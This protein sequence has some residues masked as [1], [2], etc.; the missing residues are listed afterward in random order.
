MLFRH[1]GHDD[2]INMKNLKKIITAILLIFI[3]S[4][5]FVSCTDENVTEN[6]TIDDNGTSG[7]NNESSADTDISLPNDNAVWGKGIELRIVI[8]QNSNFEIGKIINPISEITDTPAIPVTDVIEEAPHEFVLGKANRE[9]S[10]LAYSALDELLSG[11]YDAGWLLYTKGNSLA[12]AYSSDIA[13]ELSL[14]YLFDELFLRSELVFESEGVVVSHK[15]DIRS[16]AD[17]MREDARS[18]AFDNFEKILGKESTD[19][20]KKLYELYTSDLCSWFAGLYDKDIGGFYFSNSGRDNAGFLPDIESTVQALNHLATGGMFVNYSNSYAYALPKEMKAALLAFAKGLQ[21]SED[22]YFYHPQWGTSIIVSRRGRD[23]GW[24]TQLIKSLGGRPYWNTPGG[25][26]GEYGAPGLASTAALTKK[27]SEKAASAVSCITQTSSYLPEYLRSLDAW[28]D[29]IDGLGIYDDPYTSGNTLAAQH[30]EIKNAGKEYID[31]LINYLNELQDEET[32][33]WGEGVTYVTMNGFMKLSS[34]YSYYVRA[35]PNVEAALRS[36]IEILL[37][38]DTPERDLHICN[39][40]NTW[41]NFTQILSSAKKTDGEAKVNELRAI[42]RAK[43]PELIKITY[44]KVKTHKRSEGGFS[45][46]ETKTCNASQKAPVACAAVPESDVNATAIS[47]TG[48]VSNMF[49]ALGV[50]KVPVYCAEDFDVFLEILD[51][52]DPIVKN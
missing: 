23:L 15:Y 10:R 45:Y 34:S 3:L 8:A 38:P 18:E 37:T 44:E 40:Y 35:V 7:D 6:D 13:K 17:E 16:Y 22:G 9:L 28:K 29:Y 20:L 12:L 47:V 36:T 50:D 11:E 5:S 39:T 27:L 49:G 14:E 30:N 31:Y 26:A 52:K 48:I 33:F 42:I 1:L 41:V 43:A 46:F 25:V 2:K 32:G 21:S 51:T 19:E 24:A 4:L